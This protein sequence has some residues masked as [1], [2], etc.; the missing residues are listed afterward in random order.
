M[1]PQ[2]ARLAFVPFLKQVDWYCDIRKSVDSNNCVN[3]KESGI[4]NLFGEIHHP[5]SNKVQVLKNIVQKSIFKNSTKYDKR[6][7]LLREHQY[8][9][10]KKKSNS[11]RDIKSNKPQKYIQVGVVFLQQPVKEI[12]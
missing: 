8:K 11:C 4:L 1:K 3:S 6:W 5:I 9:T 12:K 7:L 10:G 2:F